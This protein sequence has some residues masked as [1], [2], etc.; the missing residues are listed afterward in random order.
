MFAAALYFVTTMYLLRYV[1]QPRV[2]PHDK[3]FG[4]AAAYLLLGVLWAYAYAIVGYF[5]PNSYLVVGNAGGLDYRGR[6]VPL[7]LGSGTK[8]GFAVIPALAAGARPVHRAGDHG[9]A[10]PGHPDCAPRGRRS[11]RRRSGDDAPRRSL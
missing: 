5:Y 3:L 9:R 8:T 10:V 6:A 7:D 11:T 2:M 4:A 1:F